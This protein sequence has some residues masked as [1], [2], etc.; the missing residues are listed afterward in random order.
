MIAT[1]FGH[2]PAV[3]VL[4]TSAQIERLETSILG[5]ILKVNIINPSPLKS[6]QKPSADSAVLE[7]KDS[8]HACLILALSQM[9]KAYFNSVKKVRIRCTSA[10]CRHK[11]PSTTFRVILL[12]WQ[13]ADKI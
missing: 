12:T 3:F 4:L 13:I 6:A 8:Q 1:S 9:P 7:T 2:L 10:H 11:K 5:T